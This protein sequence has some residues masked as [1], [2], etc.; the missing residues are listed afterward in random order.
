MHTLD[1]TSVF[2]LGSYISNIAEFD[3]DRAAVLTLSLFSK[4]SDI[5]PDLAPAPALEELAHMK[6]LGV[7]R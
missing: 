6:K 2:C 4:K 7:S 1:H 5:R 3:W